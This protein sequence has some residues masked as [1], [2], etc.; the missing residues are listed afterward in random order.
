MFIHAVTSSN[1][2]AKE[3]S[4]QQYL[5]GGVIDNLITESEREVQ[6]DLR[7]QGKRVKL[8]CTPLVL[9]DKE[10]ASTSFTGSAEAAEIERGIWVS[11]VTS[12]SGTAT[13]TLYGS[14]E[15]TGA[16]EAIGEM[17]FTSPGSQTFLIDGNNLYNYYQVTYSGTS[18]VFSSALYESSFYMAILNLA[19]SKAFLMLA[20]DPGDMFTRKYEIYRDR[21]EKEMQTMLASYDSDGDG[22]I[23]DDEYRPVKATYISR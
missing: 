17:T 2:F 20:K 21:Y 18:I 10:V 6:S 22:V 13:V 9:A 3:P 16:Y 23:E 14:D 12:L 8:Y 7:N 4:L 19:M 5:S 11:T 1:I 15:E